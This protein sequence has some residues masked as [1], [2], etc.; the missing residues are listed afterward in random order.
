MQ[1]L[2]NIQ[3]KSIKTGEDNSYLRMSLPKSSDGQRRTKKSGGA[4]IRYVSL[5]IFII[6]AFV[7]GGVGSFVTNKFILPYLSTIPFLEQY[8]FLQSDKPVVIEK[9]EKVTLTEESGVIEAVKKVSPAVVSITSARDMRGF[10][11]NTFQQKSGGTGFIV[12]N[13][14]LIATNKH[15][16]ADSSASYTVI[17]NDGKTFNAKIVAR[18]PSND[19]AI[20]KI[21]AENLPVVE[22]GNSADLEVG[23][24]VI[25][26]GNTLGEYQNTVTTGVVSAMG[27][28][29]TAGNSLFQTE[30]LEDVI[31]TDAAINPGNSGGPLVNIKG[32]VIG[33]NTAT[34][35]QGQLVGFAIPIDNLKTVIESVIREGKIVRPLVGVRSISISKEL[36]SMN[37]LPV[38]HGAL[39]YT[40]DPSLLP[41]IPGSPAQKAGLKELDIITKINNEEITGTRS[42]ATLIQ[43]YKPGEEITLTVLREDKTLE[44]KLTLGKI[45][46]EE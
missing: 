31:Q 38:D 33:I 12:T 1:D 28:S 24:R 25:A 5:I 19:F 13:D 20:I 15:V 45:A 11:G 17:T 39:I 43:K 22:L 16:V 21:E 37:K 10:F 4:R 30:S 36:A 29:I 40:G 44:I 3:I 34:D 23:Q 7:A 41:V 2:K 6:I 46:N 35:Q 9:K 8:S 42:L 18:D 26:I 32:Q 27:R 14:G